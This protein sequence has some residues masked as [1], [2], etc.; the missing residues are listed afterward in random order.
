LQA[1]NTIVQKE[2]E[3]KMGKRK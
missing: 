2:K 1:I 3:I